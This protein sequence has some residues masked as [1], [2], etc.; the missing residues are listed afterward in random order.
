MGS[1]YEYNMP[2]TLFYDVAKVSGDNVD[3]SSTGSII[4]VELKLPENLKH[5]GTIDESDIVAFQ[6]NPITGEKNI[7]NAIAQDT[8]NTFAFEFTNLGPFCIVING[9]Y[10]VVDNSEDNY[11]IK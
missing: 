10:N 8:E 3:Y 7:F 6:I 2:I 5:L 4:T 1:D 11:I 9:S